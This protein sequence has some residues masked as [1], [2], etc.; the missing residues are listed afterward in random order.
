MRMYT[1]IVT[2][3][4]GE[5]MKNISLGCD[6]ECLVCNYDECIFVDPPEKNKPEGIKQ[7]EY[8]KPKDVPKCLGHPIYSINYGEDFDCEYGVTWGCEEC[9]CNWDIGGWKDPRTPEKYS[10]NEDE[11]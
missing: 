2:E 10:E 4:H 7:P 3:C 8:E 11:E 1:I 5:I 6:G 9:L